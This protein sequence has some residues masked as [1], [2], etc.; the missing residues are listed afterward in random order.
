MTE[1][2]A[3]TIGDDGCAYINGGLTFGTTAGLY[4]EVESIFRNG[5]GIRS[6]D[7][8][9]ITSTDS[10]GLA[11]LLELQSMKRNSSGPMPI[12]NAPSDLLRLAQL[13]EA[14]GLLNISGRHPES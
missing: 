7:L 3:I 8:A 13:C 9:G 5:D 14:L 1:R 11:L 6:I 10:S 2:P 4:E 12:T